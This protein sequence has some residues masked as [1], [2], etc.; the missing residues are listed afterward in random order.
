MQRAIVVTAAATLLFP[1][2]IWAI[3]FFTPSSIRLPGIS[4]VLLPLVM[5]IPVTPF[6]VFGGI[7]GS[8]IDWSGTE[9]YE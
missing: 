3:R 6:A 9:Q 8:L 7:I 2:A 5:F 4:I 1:T